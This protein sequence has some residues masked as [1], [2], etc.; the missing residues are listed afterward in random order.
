MDANTDNNVNQLIT[1]MATNVKAARKHRFVAQVCGC[2]IPPLSS[3]NFTGQA[4]RGRAEQIGMCRDIEC[5]V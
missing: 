5:R 4:R 1:D 3:S 2:Q